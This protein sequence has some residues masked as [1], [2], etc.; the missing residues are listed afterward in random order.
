MEAIV[1]QSLFTFL[2]SISKLAS[3]SQSG[4]NTKVRSDVLRSDEFKIIDEFAFRRWWQRVED[5]ARD[6]G[7]EPVACWQGRADQVLVS[8]WDMEDGTASWNKEPF[9]AIRDEKVGIE[10][11]E[12]E[13]DLA[14][15]VWKAK[16]N[17]SVSYVLVLDDLVLNNGSV[18]SVTR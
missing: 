7:H 13:G 10:L 2:I 12:I 11:A 17:K 5:L 6:L 15:T 8:D 18:Q 4:G 16:G 3:P 9:V 1:H 14:D